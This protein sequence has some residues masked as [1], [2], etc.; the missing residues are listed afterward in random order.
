MSVESVHLTPIV[1]WPR[2]VRS[3]VRYW[4]TVDLTS[5]GE[6]DEWSYDREEYPVHCMLEG[7]PT[8]D[9]ESFGDTAVVLHRFGGTY[10]PVRFVV[11]LRAGV[12]P[13]DRDHALN[14]SLITAGGVTI[15][16][17]SLGYRVVAPADEPVEPPE[18]VTHRLLEF[19]LPL[20]VLRVR[21]ASLVPGEAGWPLD[22]EPTAGGPAPYELEPYPSAPAPLPADTTPSR[23]LMARCQV[24]PFLG[25]AAEMRVLSHWLERGEPQVSV[26][27]VDGAG[28]QGKTR[29]AAELAYRAMARGWTVLAAR[30][31]PAAGSVAD[32]RA[33]VDSDRLLVVIDYAERW[34][35]GDLLALVR[36]HRDAAGTVRFLFLARPA[37]GWW[38]AVK[39]ELTA[40]GVAAADLRLEPLAGT[41]RQRV[42]MFREAMLRFASVLGVRD[43][44][45]I[46]APEV[47][48]GAAYGSILALQMLALATIDAH[49]RGV[50]LG[51][52]TAAPSAYLLERER[53]HWHTDDPRRTPAHVIEKVVL[54]ATL[55]GPMPAADAVT[56]LG[57]LGIAEPGAALADHSAYYPSFDEDAA[58]EPLYPDRLGE[59]FLASTFQAPDEPLPDEGPAWQDV[60]DIVGDEPRHARTALAVLTETARRWPHVVA[61]LLNPLLEAR[62]SV[63][64]AA[65][66]TTLAALADIPGLTQQALEGV[67]SLFPDH[68]NVDLDVGVAAFTQR[69]VTARTTTA[70]APEVRGYQQQVLAR[71]M[72]NAGFHQNALEAAHQAVVGYRQMAAKDP[73]FESELA[74]ALVSLGAAHTHLDTPQKALEAAEEAATIYRR[75]AARR[76][77][78]FEASLAGVLNNLAIVLAGFDR[79]D[80]ALATAQEAVGIRRRLAHADPGRYEP[81]L[82][83]SLIN[84]SARLRKH[85]RW[86]Q[87]HDIAQESVGV[88]RRLTAQD[89]AAF[90]PEF[91]TALT[92]LSVSLTDLG[93]LSDALPTIQEATRLCRRLVATNPAAFALELATI[94][95]ILG[96][97]L[98]DLGQAEPAVA[99]L[100]EA[101]D[102]HRRLTDSGQSGAS[103]AYAI[104]LTS[105]G[106]ALID[107]GRYDAGIRNLQEAVTDL[108]Q[109]THRY[110]EAH[111]AALALTLSRLGAALWERGDREEALSPVQQAAEL[112]TTLTDA[113]PDLFGFRRAFGLKNLAATLAY[114]G[115]WQ[116]ADRYCVEATRCFEGLAVEAPQTFNVH[117]AETCADHSRV[118]RRMSH[119]EEAVTVLSRAVDVY[120]PLAR[121]DHARYGHRL[122]QYLTDLAG[123]LMY[124]DRDGEAAAV[125]EEATSIRLGSAE[126]DPVP[127]AD[128]SGRAQ[129]I[130]TIANLLVNA[131]DSPTWAEVRQRF[132]G[133]LPRGAPDAERA[134]TMLD[135]DAKRLA[136]LTD[137]PLRGSRR[138]VR[139]AWSTRL[140]DLL[141]EYPEMTEPL[142]AI[143][144]HGR[145]SQRVEPG[146]AGSRPEGDVRGE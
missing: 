104:S 9:V 137:A 15:Q 38:E 76:P 40:L 33:A 121:A 78:D 75:L 23:L 29:L 54:V 142:R 84:L 70:T 69:V 31:V 32:R 132:A 66:G 37:R 118:L 19:P 111:R 56:L 10:G 115:R 5:S 47:L 30:H 102:I 21:N 41:H 68:R 73:W 50:A 59:D 61:G 51:A 20:A 17:I 13:G 18:L 74:R 63:A 130:A 8:L 3:E 34:P 79:Q 64:I 24:M 124:L 87:A 133:T 90:A 4:V 11:T 49:S 14:L 119:P 46:P 127:G 22:A 113:V 129:L 114:L 105:L 144:T 36:D 98:T 97:T 92:N 146:Q 57:R 58:L 134:M 141:S 139:L 82:A 140:K 80:E 86:Q 83:V 28:G 71:R 110:P 103:A 123:L 109:R 1:S 12:T 81:E 145:P 6:L 72:A 101:T 96:A 65:G 126:Q 52:G 128:P 116:E 16:T 143:A 7:G 120:R 100:Q 42:T 107:V 45:G 2:E 67:E 39:E 44:D 117:L 138:A 91:A 62:P 122:D 55:L 136:R 99:A 108:R 89:P 26:R 53:S 88:Y 135:S 27:L 60:L 131:M 43:H 94:L 95:S 93:R 77:G 35:L 112:Y 85:G 25:R 48:R 125:T 106:S